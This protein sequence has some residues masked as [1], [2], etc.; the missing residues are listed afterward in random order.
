ME[1]KLQICNHVTAPFSIATQPKKKEICM[2]IQTKP[3][4]EIRPYEKNPWQRYGCGRL[5]EFSYSSKKVS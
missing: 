4:T 3:I 1:P 2:Q 5:L